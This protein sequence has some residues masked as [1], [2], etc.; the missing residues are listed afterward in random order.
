MLRRCGLIGMLSFCALL[1]V[2]AAFAPRAR[3]AD[4]APPNFAA[5]PTFSQGPVLSAVKIGFT[6]TG[7]LVPA[8]LVNPGYS[9][10]WNFVPGEN[11]VRYLS[12]FVFG[13]TGIGSD[14]TGPGQAFDVSVGAGIGVYNRLISIGYQESL[15][16][17]GLGSAPSSGLLYRP[18]RADGA[19][20]IMLGLNL[21]IGGLL[22]KAET[23]AP[24][25]AAASP[26]TALSRLRAVFI[27]P[28]RAAPMPPA[29]PKR[30]PPG[31]LRW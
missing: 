9:L 18:S 29:P 24:P 6:K 28:A 16:N 30:E 14:L 20:V 5:A 21:D 7:D 17:V 2:Q 19:F 4:I 15:L 13:T 1:G 3:A 12:I 23:P 26:V 31:Y 27:P 22:T 25:A 10:N 11:G 8:A